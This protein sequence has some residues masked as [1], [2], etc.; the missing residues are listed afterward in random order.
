MR[1]SRPGPWLK[2][3]LRLPV[4]DEARVMVRRISDLWRKTYPS[5]YKVW[6]RGVPMWFKTMGMSG[7]HS[8]SG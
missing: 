7:R 1:L 3:V 6:S 8:P 5:Q 2:I 4:T